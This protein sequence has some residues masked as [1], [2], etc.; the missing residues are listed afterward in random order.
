EILR[1]D[2]VVRHRADDGDS[3]AWRESGPAAA[4]GRLVGKFD[5]LDRDWT[6]S[7]CHACPNHFGDFG[8][9]ERRNSLPTADCARRSRGGAAA[10][11]IGA[12]A[13]TGDGHEDGGKRP[14]DDGGRGPE[15]HWQTL[16]AARRL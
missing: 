1:C 4:G 2:S 7:E 11:E 12:A 9:R 6:G 16:Y 8:H 5:W 14:R 15:R 13:A 3:A 10:R